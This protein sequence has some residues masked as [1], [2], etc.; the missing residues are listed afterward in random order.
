MELRRLPIV[1]MDDEVLARDGKTVYDITNPKDIPDGV[2]DGIFTVD[3]GHGTARFESR[4]EKPPY[5]TV[6]WVPHDAVSRSTSQKLPDGTQ[7]YRL[8]DGEVVINIK[9]DGE[10]RLIG[11]AQGDRLPREVL[12]F[13]LVQAL[14]GVDVT[15][16]EYA[17]ALEA[18]IE[19]WSKR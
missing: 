1:R 11:Y 12:R 18:S 3:R 7:T 6:V 17:E 9:G 4:Q 19:E 15:T 10:G 5:E 2:H 14:A 16:D 8:C 13:I